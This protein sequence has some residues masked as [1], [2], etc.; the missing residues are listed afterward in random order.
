MRRRLIWAA[1][2]L[3]LL[4][5]LVAAGYAAARTAYNRPGPLTAAADIVVP[6]GSIHAI[7]DALARA[8]A[9][10]DE[11]S[12]RLAAWWTSADGKVRAG[13]FAMPA[14][15]SLRD[16]LTVL[17]TAR[18]VLHRLTIP[19]GLTALQ[20][21]QIFD[22]NELLT[23]A[24]PALA[25]GSVLPQTYAF[26]RGTTREALLA[27]ATRAMERATA[28]AWAGRADNLPLA[29][30][31]ELVIVASIVERET[32]RA[33][34]RPQVAAVYL[35][36]LRRGMRLQADPTVSYAATSGASLDRPP[37]RTDLDSASPYNTYR[38]TGLPPTPIASPGLAS[39]TA[40]AHPAAS[41]ALYF[42]ADG[43][44]RHVFAA[45]L[46]EHNRNVARWRAL[47]R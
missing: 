7:G 24:T 43:T 28:E 21:A 6:P 40:T 44:G 16:V 25:E 33:E 12:F 41:D 29:S 18:P 36:R 19:E 9:I 15:A 30:P 20:I 23:G 3:L 45:T 34:E 13:E 22:H 32:A 39:L 38:A 27:R 11:R 2:T 46:D 1:A 8:G 26:E 4:A 5:G 37:T 47:P 10:A 14:H 42:V 31:R 35:N 17:R